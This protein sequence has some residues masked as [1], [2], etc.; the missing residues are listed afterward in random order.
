MPAATIHLAGAAADPQNTGLQN[1]Q[2]IKN[3]AQQFESILLTS[4]IGPLEKSFSVLPGKDNDP[5]SGQYQSM[6]T[7]AL[8]T[9]LSSA[10][11]L[12]IA[13]MI[14]AS[15]MKTPSASAASPHQVSGNYADLGSSAKSG[16]NINVAIGAYKRRIS[17]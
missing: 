4:L 5:A 6:E 1:I 8:A 17:F 13:R 12:G 15:L 16:S 10:G 11:G 7:Q 3:V 9:A 14:A 2:K